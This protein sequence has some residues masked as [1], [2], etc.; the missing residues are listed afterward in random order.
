[1]YRGLVADIV[2]SIDGISVNALGPVR[3]L[4]LE[5]GSEAA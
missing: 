3:G 4:E 5:E 1:M 2:A